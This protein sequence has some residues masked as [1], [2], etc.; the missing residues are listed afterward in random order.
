MM[1][2]VGPNEKDDDGRSYADEPRGDDQR[3]RMPLPELNR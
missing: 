1:Y 2:S 3:I